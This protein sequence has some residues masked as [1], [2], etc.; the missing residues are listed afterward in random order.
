MFALLEFQ[1]HFGQT[2][3]PVERESRRW[4]ALFAVAQRA[5]ERTRTSFEDQNQ[6]CQTLA[7]F[8]CET[9]LGPSLGALIY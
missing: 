4:A 2:Q 6:S 7:F 5:K 1:A 9:A 8:T 3:T